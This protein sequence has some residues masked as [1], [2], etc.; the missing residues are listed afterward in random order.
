M[1]IRFKLL[2]GSHVW[3]NPRVV[4]IVD[5]GKAVLT[6]PGRSSEYTDTCR[7][8]CGPGRMY[9]LSVSD[10]SFVRICRAEQRKM[11][12]APPLA[13]EHAK[14]KPVASKDA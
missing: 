11:Q 14:K 1:V 6:D 2:K 12:T 13:R 4:E 9:Q 3:I 7:V 8:D 5:P 10:E